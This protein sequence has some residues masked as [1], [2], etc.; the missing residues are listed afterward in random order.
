MTEEEAYPL[1][2][3]VNEWAGITELYFGFS[4]LSIITMIKG[5]IVTY[6]KK[7]LIKEQLSKR[8]SVKSWHRNGNALGNEVDNMPPAQ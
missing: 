1:K 8:L 3:M 2:E 6:K 5:T 4:F 7:H